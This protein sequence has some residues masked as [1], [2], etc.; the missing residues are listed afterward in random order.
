MWLSL[1][2]T[3][4][5]YAVSIFRPRM[6]QR[7]E[8]ERETRLKE[9]PK[10]EERGLAYCCQDYATGEKETLLFCIQGQ[11]QAGASLAGSQYLTVH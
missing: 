2:S 6:I 1:F 9:R 4:W 3:I 10:G 7:M 5:K 11:T 8:K